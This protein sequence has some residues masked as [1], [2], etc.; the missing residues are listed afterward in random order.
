MN[1][2]NYYF[3]Y[4]STGHP[5]YG[6]WTKIEAPSRQVAVEIFRSLHPDRYPGTVHCADIYNEA[7]FRRTSMW[8]HGNFGHHEHEVVLMQYINVKQMEV[9]KNA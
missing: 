5:F 1:I 8:R 2:E 3:T 6:G 9:E 4:G 7:Q